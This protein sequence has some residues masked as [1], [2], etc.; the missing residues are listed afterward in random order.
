MIGRI[1]VG[2]LL[3]IVFGFFVK[4][5]FLSY[6]ALYSCWSKEGDF[7]IGTMLLILVLFWICSDYY[8]Y[9]IEWPQRLFYYR[10]MVDETRRLI[11]KNPEWNMKDM[12]MGRELTERIS[13]LRELQ[14]KIRIAKR[15]PFV[16]FKPT[17]NE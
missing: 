3:L 16:I 17:I 8:I 5:V 4:G 7:M 14:S 13:D 9:R 1:F 15:S 11:D 2:I 6:N 12:Q 10:E